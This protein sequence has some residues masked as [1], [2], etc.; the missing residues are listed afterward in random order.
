M[1]DTD[2]QHPPQTNL[3][4]HVCIYHPE[5][6]G[7]ANRIYGEGRVNEQLK[8]G[9]ISS[10][11]ECLMCRDLLMYYT[12]QVD[13]IPCYT[14]VSEGSIYQLIVPP[15]KPVNVPETEDIP[16]YELT[17]RKEYIKDYRD[18]LLGMATILIYNE[19]VMTDVEEFFTPPEGKRWSDFT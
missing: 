2:R 17:H 10:C 4:L 16:K 7:M 14:E 1:T 13:D 6:L 9:E 11:N 12:P 8:E 5:H 18:K 3:N 15:L 19:V